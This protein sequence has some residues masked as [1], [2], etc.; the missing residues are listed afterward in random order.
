MRSIVENLTKISENITNNVWGGIIFSIVLLLIVIILIIVLIYRQNKFIQ[1]IINLCENLFFPLI[2]KER[3]IFEVF[4]KKNAVVKSVED[5]YT[6]IGFKKIKINCTDKFENKE[7][8]TEKNL[9]KLL[10]KQRKNMSK[11]KKGS[12]KN[13][14]LVYLG[15]PHVPIAF[16]DGV[17]FS[18]VN[19]VILYEY[20]GAVGNSPDKDFFELKK[21]YNSSIELESNYKEITLNSDEVIIKIEQSFDINDRELI[22]L[23]GDKDIIYLSNKDRKRWGISSYSD[24]DKFIKE[25]EKILKWAKENNIKKI[26]LFMT[27][28]VSLTFS[29]GQVVSHY[30]PDIIIYNYNNNNFDWCVD[31]KNRK[32]K[33]IN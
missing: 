28:P 33:I 10:D 4:T 20:D 12:K 1:K 16:V 11:I 8:V 5:M 29:L 18:D 26:H 22:N 27:T 24:V 14:S 21:I 19:N 15:F 32:V 13:N 31:V 23:V 17:N 3:I 30:T 6:L 7:W 25:F 9:Q 2:K